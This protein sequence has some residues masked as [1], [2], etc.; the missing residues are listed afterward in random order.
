[1][2]LRGD[3]LEWLDKNQTQPSESEIQAEITR[4][5]AEYDA[6]QYQRD[7]ATQY[8][9]VTD[10]LD[11]LWHAIDTGTLDKTCDFY[12]VNKTVKDNNPKE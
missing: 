12:T 11:M 7:R 4:L 2:D 1:V 8:K 6:N 10:Q 9:P 5:Q 3:E